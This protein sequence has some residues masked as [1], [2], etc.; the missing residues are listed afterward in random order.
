MTSRAPSRLRRLMN[1]GGSL[2]VLAVVFLGSALLRAVGDGGIAIAQEIRQPR[3]EPEL[4]AIPAPVCER[5]AGVAEALAAIL[6]RE[7]RVAQREERLDIR[8][9]ALELAESEVRA[10][11]ERL[12]VA[13]AALKETLTL[14]DSAA[15]GDLARLTSVYENMKPVNAAPLFQ[16]MEPEFAAGFLGRMRP[17]AAAAIMAGLEPDLAYAISVV[18]AGRN[19]GAPI[20]RVDDTDS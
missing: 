12:A 5:E 17:D 15:E 18:I 19:A 14:A 9:Q 10:D 2:S 6:E 4:A 7:A 13:E 8:L 16:Q 3:P 11:L 20:R 1:G